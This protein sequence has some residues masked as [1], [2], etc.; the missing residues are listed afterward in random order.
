MAKWTRVGEIPQRIPVNFVVDSTKYP[1]LAAWIYAFPHGEM[2]KAVRNILDRHV[3]ATT[4]E[5]PGRAGG[6][7]V[8]HRSGLADTPSRPET[9]AVREEPRRQPDVRPSHHPGAPEDGATRGGMDG[10]TANVLNELDQGF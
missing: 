9:P 10:G 1:E 3:K 6:D 2:G 8:P 4:P 5:T 7:D